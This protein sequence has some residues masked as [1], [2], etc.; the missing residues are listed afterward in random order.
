MIAPTPAMMIGLGFVLGYLCGSIPFGVVFARLRGVDLQKVGS[1]NIGAT[2]AARALG[3]KIGVVVLLC[4]A[5]KAVVPLLLVRRQLAGYL[6]LE[7]VLAALAF[8][9]VAGHMLSPWLRFRGGKGVA[10]GFGAF[11]VLVPLEAAVAAVAWVALY[12]LTRVS[13][14]GSLVAVTALPVILVLRGEAWAWVALALALWPLIIWKHRDNIRRL[15]RRE[16][17]RV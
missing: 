11:L 1:G 15:L 4:D 6:Q 10:T 7:W 13:S 2:N 8:G 14:I 5:G 9:A 12:A 16:E 3:K 17:T